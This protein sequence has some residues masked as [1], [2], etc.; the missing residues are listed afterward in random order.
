MTH[1][2]Q[3]QA[4]ALK[5]CVV[6][7]KL[8]DIIDWDVRFITSLAW[9]ADNARHKWLTDSQRSN[10]KRLL[11]RYTDEMIAAGHRSLLFSEKPK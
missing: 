8:P 3:N 1:H 5:A 10:L 2:E 7:A 4:K 9:A 11:V 6:D